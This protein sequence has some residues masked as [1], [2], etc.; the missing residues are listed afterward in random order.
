L[1]PLAVSGYANDRETA[2]VAFRRQL[3]RSVRSCRAQQSA[4]SKR[5]PGKWAAKKAWAI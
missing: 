4:R 1:A 2:T 5:C 3:S